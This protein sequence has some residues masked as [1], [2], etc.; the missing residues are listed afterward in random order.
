MITLLVIAGSD[1]SGGAGIQAD[2]KTSASLGAHAVTAVTA[3]TAQNSLGI[4]AVHKL[5]AGFISRQIEILLEDL[6]PSAVKIGMLYT[7]TAVREV[8][9][10]LREHKL[11]PVVVDPVLKAST[12]R[13]LLE[14]DAV[15]ALKDELFP[16]TT[17]VTPNLYE[18]EIL[19]G[20]KLANV[21]EMIE[22]ARALKRFGPDVVITGGHCTDKC[23]DLVFDGTDVHQFVGSKIT[24]KHTHGSG[25]VFSTALAVSLSEEKSLVKA[26]EMAHDF[27]RNAILNGYACGRGS[28]PVK[29][30]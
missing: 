30:G 9:K 25:C 21:E 14:Q 24:T 8:A 18:A 11:K 4:T 20:K 13:E 3:V 26:V 23:V 17:V 29:A 12:G 5:P 19:S 1:S 7:A 22:A 16:L 2:I 27:T 10:L 6:V 28:G 15:S